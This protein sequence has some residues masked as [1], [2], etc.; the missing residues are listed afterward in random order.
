MHGEATANC[1]ELER[2]GERETNGPTAISTMPLLLSESH[3]TL[4][5]SKHGGT[6]KKRASLFLRV[7]CVLTRNR[8]SSLLFEATLW[9]TGGPGP[10]SPDR[11]PRGKE[12][13]VLLI[14]SSHHRVQSGCPFSTGGLRSRLRGPTEESHIHS[15]GPGWAQDGYSSDDSQGAL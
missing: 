1:G 13:R 9:T 7:K 6:K 8:P 3:G 14:P 4:L 11:K 12:Q 5:K 10:R 15:L 2:E